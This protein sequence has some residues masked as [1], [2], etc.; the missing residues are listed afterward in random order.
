MPLY[1]SRPQSIRPDMVYGSASHSRSG[2]SHRMDREYMSDSDHAHGRAMHEHHQSQ[3]RHRSSRRQSSLS[4]QVS[5]PPPPITAPS[6]YHRQ[7]SAPSHA[8][9]R[10]PRSARD[11][12]SVYTTTPR[13]RRT[14][15]SAPA[16][17]VDA[18][19]SL[20]SLSLHQPQGGLQLSFIPATSGSSSAVSATGQDSSIRAPAPQPVSSRT[21]SL[22]GGLWNVRSAR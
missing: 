3:T 4:S 9:E 17:A 1:S 2:S 22:L 6:T 20:S 8:S 21:S 16:S 5:I 13:E 7:P 12:S 10:G 19:A 11:E 15:S 18:S 14:H